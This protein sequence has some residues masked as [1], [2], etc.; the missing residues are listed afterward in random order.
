M[1]N[2]GEYIAPLVS[3][4][5]VALS[6]WLPT[7][8]EGYSIMGFLEGVTP[9]YVDYLVPAYLGVT[10]AVLF[11][12]KEK[13]ALGSQRALRRSL[14]PDVKY[15]L[16]T[17]LFTLLI[18]YP[19]LVGLGVVIDPKVSDFINALLGFAI[20][21]FALF[22]GRFRPLLGGAKEKI[23]EDDGAT[24]VDSIVSGLL[25]GGTLMGGFS[26]SGFVFFGL[27]VTGVTP[28]KA[29]ELSFLI[30]PVYFILKL[31]FVGGWDPALPVPL[32]F[33][34]FLSAFVTSIVTMKG[35]LR[36]VEVFGERVFLALFGLIPVFVYLVG[37]VL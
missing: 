25:Q 34:A 23:K 18:G 28:K 3:G 27:V 30:A 1:V 14:D 22:M 7:S 24:L 37:V 33:A 13:I 4:V 32:L 26:R 16:Y 11:Y 12:F 36:A 8:P 29:L 15:L 31:A 9:A 19:L 35:L 21:L 10:F 6:S 2:I 17:T 5:V 20:F